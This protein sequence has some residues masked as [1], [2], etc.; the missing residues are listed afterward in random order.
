M[1]VRRYSISA[2]I[3]TADFTV[4]YYIRLHTGDGVPKIAV[5]DDEIMFFSSEEKAREEAKRIMKE[6][7]QKEINNEV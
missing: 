5:E 3:N 4:S 2:A 6:L 7:K 1:I